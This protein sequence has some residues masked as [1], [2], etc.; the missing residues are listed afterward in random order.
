MNAHVIDIVFEADSARHIVSMSRL[1]ASCRQPDG[2]GALK[3]G[4]LKYL[5]HLLHASLNSLRPLRLARESCWL[6][7]PKELE[8]QLAP[9]HS[10]AQHDIASCPHRH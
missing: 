5:L 7:Q 8:S 6:E 2:S 4:M 1:F 3:S 9:P 10:P